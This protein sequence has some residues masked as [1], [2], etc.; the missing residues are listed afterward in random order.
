MKY[1]KCSNVA[2]N[3]EKICWCHEDSEHCRLRIGWERRDLVQIFCGFQ[4]KCETSITW[5]SSAHTFM[6][7][8]VSNNLI[9][10]IHNTSEWKWKSCERF[11]RVILSI[12]IS[13][14]HYHTTADPTFAPH[15]QRE[16]CKITQQTFFNKHSWWLFPFIEQISID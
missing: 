1:L 15:H 7:S 13:H 14:C 12:R 10:L 2:S 8:R 6:Q 4:L 11:C 5:N 3:S 16:N 9:L